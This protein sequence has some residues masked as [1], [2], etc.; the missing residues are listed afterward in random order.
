MLS[1]DQLEELLQI[2]D[3]NHSI[4][5]AQELGVD[6]LSTGDK[7][8]LTNNGV[9]WKNLYSVENDSIFTA[10][11]LGLLAD[12]LKGKVL[13]KIPYIDLKDFIKKGK[14]IPLTQREKNIIKHIKSQTYKD[15]KSLK[16]KI[17]NDTNQILIDQ[18]LRG[19]RTFIKKEILNG[20]KDK[21][22]IK[23]IA[24]E[25]SKKTGDYTRNFDRIVAYN[26]QDS[27]ESGKAESIRN[28]YGEDSLVYKAVFD[29]ACKHCIRLY[30][31]NG[32]GSEPRVFKLSELQA[33]GSNIGRK[34][35]DYL[36]TIPPTHCFCRCNVF[37]IFPGYKWNSVTKMFDI[38]TL[39]KK[40]RPTVTLTI[41]G[42]EYQI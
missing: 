28:T 33:N 11:H 39:P 26:V 20:V 30:L 3:K 10:F 31:T 19:Q 2:I 13:D 36:P 24:L 1:S 27:Y 5:I 25:I 32:P 29:K 41:G 23:E 8:I 35:D 38:S 9:D 22:S 17:F 16:G 4:F 21:K 7:R 12:S 14:Y 34:V 15:L 18:T 37:N 42:K 40:I 6:F